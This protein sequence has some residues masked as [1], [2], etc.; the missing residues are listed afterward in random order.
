MATKPSSRA[1][2]LKNSSWRTASYIFAL[3]Q[4]S[5]IFRIL[6]LFFRILFFKK[7]KIF[8]MMLDFSRTVSSTKLKSSTIMHAS[9][10]ARIRH[11]RENWIE[12]G[13]RR[14]LLFPS[15]LFAKTPNYTQFLMIFFCVISPLLHLGLEE[16]HSK[17]SGLLVN[18]QTLVTKPFSLLNY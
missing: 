17:I 14:E 9:V 13:E 11:E 12:K 5:W 2:T 1:C 10:L 16:A 18:R 8:L 3:K 4:L 6:L 15:N 7:G